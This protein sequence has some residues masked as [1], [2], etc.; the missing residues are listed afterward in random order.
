MILARRSVARTRT[1]SP[2]CISFCS[3]HGLSVRHRCSTGGGPGLEQQRLL[4]VRHPVLPIAAVFEGPAGVEHGVYQAPVSG[5]PWI[6]A[7]LDAEDIQSTAVDAGRHR[8]WIAEELTHVEATV[9]DQ[10]LRVYGEPAGAVR[11]QDVEVVQIAVE[12]NRL[13]GRREQ[14]RA[15]RIC[16][17]EQPGGKARSA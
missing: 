17:L 5:A 13:G 4:G 2:T 7:Q 11:A 3:V 6:Q 14:V 16:P 10:A 1:L 12:C 15:Q 9:P 8:F